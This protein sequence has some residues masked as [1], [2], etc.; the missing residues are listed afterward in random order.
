[1]LNRISREIERGNND[2]NLYQLAA[3]KTEFVGNAVVGRLKYID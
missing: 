3:F 2:R 1:M